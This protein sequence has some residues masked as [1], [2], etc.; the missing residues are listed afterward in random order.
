MMGGKL[1]PEQYVGFTYGSDLQGHP[2]V[3][4]SHDSHKRFETKYAVNAMLIILYNHYTALLCFEIRYK[5]RAEKRQ[6]RVQRFKGT[7]ELNQVFQFLRT[8]V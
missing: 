5:I 2:R 4:S 6:F 7:K 3:V 8:S 1:Y